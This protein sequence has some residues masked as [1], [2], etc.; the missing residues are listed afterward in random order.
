MEPLF[1]SLAT[2]LVWIAASVVYHLVM[3]FIAGAFGIRTRTVRIGFGPTLFHKQVGNWI[4]SLGAIPAGGYT[5]FHGYDEHGNDEQGEEY[6][7]NAEP[8]IP[9][10]SLWRNARP[11]AQMLTILSG[12]LSIVLLSAICLAVPVLMGGRQLG[13][14][15]TEQANIHPTGVPGLTLYDQPATSE[16]QVSLFR[17]TVVEWTLRLATFQSMDGWGGLIAFFWTCGGVGALSFGAWLSSTG[18]LLLGFGL[19]NLLPVP[20]LNGFTFLMTAIRGATGRKVPEN[21]RIGFTYVGLVAVLLFL[22]R[23][24]WVDYRWLERLFS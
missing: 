20:V 6:L 9:A 15:S 21:V 22:G 17:E 14:S 8:P 4:F 5:Q 18:V 24:L 10:S 1:Y 11:L 19:F 2:L 3:V 23:A 7:A 12:P 16:G 13:V